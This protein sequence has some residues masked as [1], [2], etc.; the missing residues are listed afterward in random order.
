MLQPLLA[1]KNKVSKGVLCIMEGKVILK[2]KPIRDTTVLCETVGCSFNDRGLC[3]ADSIA[4][5]DGKCGLNTTR[6]E[7]YN[8]SEDIAAQSL[9]PI[10]SCKN[11][12]SSFL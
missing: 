11:S 8:E 5:I 7:A 1:N 12:Y 3:E 10:G 9:T 2:S 4:I 6:P